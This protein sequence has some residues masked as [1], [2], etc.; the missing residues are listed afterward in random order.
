MR[1]DAMTKGVVRAPHRSLFKA[2]GYTDEELRRPMIG[3]AN[4]ANEIIP[5]H[6]HLDRITEAVKAG[7]RMAGGTPVE[8]RTIG[9]CDGIAM[10]HEGMKY[11]LVSR[12]IIA[13]SIEIMA[14]AH[15]FDGIVLVANC[16]KIVP[17]MLMALLRLNIPGLY[18]SGGPM[19]TGRTAGQSVDL[20][21]V[22]EGVGRLSAGTLDDAGLALLEN[23]A[24]PGCGSCAGMFTANSMN[25]VS[26][27]LGLS[28]PGNGT[29]PAVHA[30]RVRLAKEAGMRA[31]EMVFAGR[32]PRQVATPDAFDNAIAVDLAIGAS[33]NTVLHLPAIA[34]EAGFELP[35]KR[36]D[37]LSRKTPNIC[38]LSPAS[39][40]HIEDLDAAGGIPAVMKEIAGLGLIHTDCMTVSGRSVADILKE[41][42][43][44][45]RTVI[46]PVGSPHSPEGGLAVLF[47][48]LAPDGAVVKQS[49]VAPSM[50]RFSGRARVFDGEEAALEAL[51]AGGIAP[52]DAVVIRYEGPR[53]GPG[54]REML[55][56]TSALH[57]KGLGEQVAL[58][59]DGRF[60][61]GTRGGCIGHISPEAAAGGPIAFVKDKD[62]IEIDIP[63]RRIDLHV[64]QE[65]MRKRMTGWAPPEKR[66]TGVLSR[67][68]RL[69]R[70][71]NTG[72]RLEE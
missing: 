58:L 37:E 46:R 10:G 27:A 60:S 28:L 7:I 21:S 29:I 44:R 30:A 15:P 64:P 41:A 54:M 61:G 68:A 66:L 55:A 36:F 12:E 4:A 67:Y 72:A 59:T 26:E 32:T 9:V 31:V 57:G 11:S 47:G 1:S 19:L 14:C 6:I 40:T 34:A 56:V 33:T 35:L 43:V 3:V 62:R 13:D 45:D 5:G 53:G 63:G 39:S 16:D 42:Q 18:V 17:G 48:S 65:E 51:L 24:C 52:G 49:A 23:C 70:P 20:I 25:C 8:F 71:A 2:M 69:V 38:R 22:F 50:M